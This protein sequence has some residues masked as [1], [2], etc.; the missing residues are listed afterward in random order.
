[1]LVSRHGLPAPTAASNYRGLTVSHCTCAALQES[2]NAQEDY[3]TGHRV[4][5]AS[6]CGAAAGGL[7]GAGRTLADEQA[8][9]ALDRAPVF[10]PAR[11]TIMVHWKPRR[12]TKA[13][14]VKPWLQQPLSTALGRGVCEIYVHNCDGRLWARC[15]GP[16]CNSSGVPCSGL[17]CAFPGKMRSADF[18]EWW[19]SRRLRSQSIAPTRPWLGLDV[20][21]DDFG[22]DR[23]DFEAQDPKRLLRTPPVDQI[24]EQLAQA[25]DCGVE[26]QIDDHGDDAHWS[27]ESDDAAEPSYGECKSY[28]DELWKYLDPK[29]VKE[30]M[31]AGRN[32]DG[33]NDDRYY[34]K[35]TT[36]SKMPGGGST[37]R[38]R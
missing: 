1:L 8:A 26:M 25:H 11:G 16:L 14:K 12:K 27:A 24:P 15:A 37:R 33:Y 36:S 17:L 32:L 6:A 20:T 30:H 7:T 31:L 2:T 23:R 3:T 13:D 29:S 10:D 19:H 34:G 38:P 9:V 18:A 35:S 5:V 21:P 22:N 4:Q 28:F